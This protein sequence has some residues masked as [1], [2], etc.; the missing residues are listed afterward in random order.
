MTTE[1]L[2]GMLE[3][4]REKALLSREES[5]RIRRTVH[6]ATDAE[7]FCLVRSEVWDGCFQALQPLADQLQ[8]VV[9]R[10]EHQYQAC[11]E[12]VHGK[13][14]VDHCPRCHLQRILGTPGG[15]NVQR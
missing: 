12:D 9:E 2:H 7:A 5:G 1:T 6:V 10:M 3:R 13:I 11:D 8:A 4:L 14:S 15:T